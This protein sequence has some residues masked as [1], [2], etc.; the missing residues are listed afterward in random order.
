VAEAERGV[1]GVAVVLESSLRVTAC[2]YP[3]PSPTSSSP[4]DTRLSE[5]TRASNKKIV[6]YNDIDEVNLKY[7]DKEDEC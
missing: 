3:V 4:K 6:K 7:N 1:E 5:Q 2:P